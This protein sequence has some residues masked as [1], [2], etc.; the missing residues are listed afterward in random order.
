MNFLV[1]KSSL[2]P[3]LVSPGSLLRSGVPRSNGVSILKL[4]DVLRLAESDPLTGSVQGLPLGSLLVR[5]RQSL[6][7]TAPILSHD[8]VPLGLPAPGL[9][10]L[11]NSFSS[12]SPLVGYLGHDI[13][14]RSLTL[15]LPVLGSE[16][17]VDGLG[18]VRVSVLGGQWLPGSRVGWAVWVCM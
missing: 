10:F 1:H 9:G 13:Q 12:R 15:G 11:R 6:S 5:L 2:I 3:R 17:M 18:H 7:Q 4:P 16:S 14:C 8:P